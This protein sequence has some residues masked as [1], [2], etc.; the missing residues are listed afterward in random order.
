M[1]KELAVQNTIDSV[2]DY[3]KGQSINDSFGLEQSD[4][5][6]PLIKLLQPLSPECAS[7]PEAKAGQFWHTGAKKNLGTSFD[8]IPAHIGKKVIL[9]EPTKS[10]TGGRILAYSRDSIH[11]DSGANSEFTVN[12]KGAAKPVTWKTGKDV[13]TSG[14]LGWGSSNPDDEKSAPAAM[15]IYSYVCL[16]VDS[17]NKDTVINELSPVVFGVYK[18]G[19]PSAQDLN[20]QFLMLRGPGQKIAPPP[21][22][23][24]RCSVKTKT[25]DGLSWTI[26]VFNP[27]G[28]VKSEQVYKDAC[29]LGAQYATYQADLTEVI[30]ESEAT[31]PVV[32][33]YIKY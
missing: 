4:F 19:L 28:R 23:I 8:F 25:K 2:P 7:M 21:S 15:L 31:S 24:V 3:L 26:P 22:V 18:T 29:Q 17:A 1:S 30:A 9:Y 6:V 11:W 5:K 33:D 12:V 16:L 13:R 14:L 32:E 20:T 27:V 10:G